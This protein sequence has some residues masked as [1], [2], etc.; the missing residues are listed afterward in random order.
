MVIDDVPHFMP[1]HKHQRVVIHRAHQLS[2]NKHAVPNRC[3]IILPVPFYVGVPGKIEHTNDLRVVGVGRDRPQPVNDPPGAGLYN[4]II[5]ES[6]LL[7]KKFIPLL[8]SALP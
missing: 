4:R 6:V 2:A 7:P 3:G 5:Y 1:N 8:G